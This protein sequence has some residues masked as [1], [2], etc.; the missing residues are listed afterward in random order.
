MKMTMKRYL[1]AAVA[2]L[3]FGGVAS[4]ATQTPVVGFADRMCG[5]MTFSMG[6]SGSR[7]YVTS[8]HVTHN[9][10]GWFVLRLMNNGNEYSRTM[11]YVVSEQ[12]FANQTEW[13]GPSRRNPA[14]SMRGDLF[15]EGGRMVYEEKAYR[16]GTM[17]GDT[18]QDCGA[19]EPTYAAQ[20]AP[21]PV[22]AY[23]PPPSTPSAYTPGDDGVP[24]ISEYRARPSALGA[25]NTKWS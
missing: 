1:L 16:L 13:Y 8:T 19:A 6:N 3:A 18:L 22:T 21:A 24:L 5:P 17:I 20:P 9:G 12:S 2:A 10:S 14:F 4:A 15:N 7:E 23:A 25:V 11:Q